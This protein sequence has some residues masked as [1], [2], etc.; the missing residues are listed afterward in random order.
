MLVPGDWV[1]MV[2][3]VVVNVGPLVVLSKPF[4]TAIPKERADGEFGWGKE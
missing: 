2:V 3:V 4:S 1:G